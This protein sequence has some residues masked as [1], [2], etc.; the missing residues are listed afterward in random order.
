M[1][2]I[3]VVPEIKFKDNSNWHEKVIGEWYLNNWENE[4]IYQLLKLGS[5]SPSLGS[6]KNYDYLHIT[7]CS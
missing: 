7:A 2:V 6:T 4:E 5:V 3:W 1:Y